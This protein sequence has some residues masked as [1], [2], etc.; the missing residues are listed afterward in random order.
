MNFYEDFSNIFIYFCSFFKVGDMEMVEVSA[1]DTAWVL[2][3]S[4]LVMLM[5]PGVGLFYAGMVRR[6]NVIATMTMCFAVLALI[7]VQ[8]VLYGYTLAF[9]SDIRGLIGGLD[10]LGLRGVGLG[11]GTYAS[12][13]PHLAFMI[14]QGAFAI[15]TPALIIAA[16][17]ERIKFSSF[18]LFTLLWATFVYD[19]IAH[20]VW[21]GGWLGNLGALDFAGG[22]VVHISSGVSALAIA[23]VIGARKGFGKIPM[24]PHNVPF[25]IIGAA[26]LW[27]GWFGFNGGS[28]LGANG[29]AASAFVTTNTAAAAAA[30]TWM[31]LSWRD[32]RPSALG[33]ATGAVAGL[34]AIT[35]ASGF[36]GPLEALI[37]GV[38]AG[39]VCY[40]ALIFRMSRGIDE[41][42]DAWAVHGMG[43]TWGAVATGI[44]ASTL[45]NPEGANG[46]LYGNPSQLGVQLLAVAATWIYAFAITLIIAKLVDSLLG[47]RVSEE[48]EEVG[49][50]I[51]QH[52]ELAYS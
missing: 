9:G 22:T 6:K 33:I 10:W 29:L 7:S 1:G 3:S 12:T 41:S 14:F 23:L 32:K 42:L 30:L 48:E 35:P 52:G 2:A 50:D 49:L 24:E 47:L 26:L 20:W 28:A 44:F 37:I 4:A 15:I 39:I 27:F 45:V 11:P 34:V 18:M 8:W 25:T 38:G 36:V 51:S 31:L 17:V 19:P 46:L 16:F 5:T 40:Y 43:G 21:G 13:I